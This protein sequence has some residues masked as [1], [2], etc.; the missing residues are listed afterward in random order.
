MKDKKKDLKQ[1][2]LDHRFAVLTDPQ[3]FWQETE[4]YKCKPPKSSIHGVT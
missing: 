2:R 3:G 4:K 1:N